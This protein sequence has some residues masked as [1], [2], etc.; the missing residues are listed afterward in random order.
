MNREQLEDAIRAAC[1]V[2]GDEELWV[3]GSQAILGSHPDAPVAFRRS[4]K[5]D[6]CPRNRPE[7]VDRIDAN[8]GEASRFHRTHGFYVHGILIEEAAMLPS[9]WEERAVPVFHEVT[10]RGNTGWCL[11]TH[12]L[13]ASKLAVFRDKDRDFV[14]L[15]L[16]HELVEIEL[17]RERFED[18]DFD[19]EKSRRIS[20]WIAGIGEELE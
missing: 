11:E 18:L 19:S 13:A 17:L 6:V 1:D 2:A 15:L 16:V 14:R 12:D 4:M 7:A 5:A 20:R 8:L 9:G 3:F 10:T